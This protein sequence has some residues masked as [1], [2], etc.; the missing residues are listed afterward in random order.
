M[1]SLTMLGAAGVAAV[2]PLAQAL[3]QRLPPPPPTP[4][5]VQEYVRTPLSGRERVGHLA[6]NGAIGG[7]SAAM[8]ALARGKN[9][10]RAA[11]MGFG[12]GVTM[13]AG[14]QLAGKRFEGAGL[15]GRQ[16]AALGTS[17]VRSASEDTMVV[18]LPAGPMTFEI[19][20]SAVD[21]VRPRVN[22]VSTATVLYYVIRSDTRI[23]VG[24]TFS[25]GAPV[26]R[27][28]TETVSTRD[29]I[30]FGRMDFGTIVLGR[31]P[32][33]QDE[34]RLMTLPH[35]SIHVVQY[36][37]LEQALSLPI[38]R[39]IL[40]KLGAGEGFRRHVDVGAIS[41]LLA[42]I[43]Q[44]HMDYEDRPWEREAVIL[45]EGR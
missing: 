5:P 28:P 19:R 14:K 1:R 43:L 41:V 17:V 27:F 45:T 42:G 29:G 15:V 35:E 12:G 36:D 6:I 13:G 34:Q 37:F 8:F 40:R 33:V 9:P 7:F 11:L 3:A 21:R 22:L 25:T 23:D 10:W 2:M 16:L 4:Q 32:L 44:M 18:I 31:T 38:E 20:P 30:I 39:A 26:F 24:A